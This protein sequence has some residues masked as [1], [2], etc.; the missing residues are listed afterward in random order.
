MSNYFS[1]T[2]TLDRTAAPDLLNKQ[3]DVMWMQRDIIAGNVLGQ[4]FDKET[5][6]S[7]LTHV[8]SS[9]TASLP[10]PGE[11]EDTENLP[12]V[13]PAP[14]FDKT[15][16]LV[17]HAAGIRV[18]RT[19]LKADRFDKIVGMAKGQITSAMQKD[20]YARASI[21]NNAFTGD[22]GA[23]GKDL[24][25]DDHPCE[26]DAAGTYDKKGTGALSGPNLHALRL[27]ARKMVNAQGNPYPVTPKAL[28]VPEDL[29]Q[30]ALELTKSDGK[31]ATALNDPNVLI[32]G[33]PVIVSP[34]LSSAA[35]YYLFGDLPNYEKGLCEISLMDWQISD[36]NPN[37]A[38][39]VI[40]KEIAAIKAWSFTVSRNLFGSTGV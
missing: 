9:V 21:L 36:N 25:D 28:L 18:T 20:E 24:I 4:F 35:Q 31:P 26:N 8:I 6:D 37:R 23:D 38:S 1:A 16:T 14:G 22:D 27:L 29:E 33:L 15:I 17:N 11:V 40:D 13:T 2:G 19:M 39:I 30:V 10:L 3:I 32:N 7:G 5:K 12:Y 34:Y